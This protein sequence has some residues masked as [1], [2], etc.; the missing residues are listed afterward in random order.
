MESRFGEKWSS[1][2]EG[3]LSDERSLEVSEELN[4]ELGRIAHE[5]GP[6]AY[7]LGIPIRNA[8]DMYAKAVRRY[9][10]RSKGSPF[11]ARDSHSF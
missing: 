11:K 1:F 5:E 9:A 6:E 10:H 4:R 7:F 3:R 2:L 8:S